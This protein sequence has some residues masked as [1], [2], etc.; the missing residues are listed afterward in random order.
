MSFI[1]G[2][3][4]QKGYEKKRRKLL[5]PF[6]TQHNG[7]NGHQAH[8]LAHASVD[9]HLACKT[10]E[11]IPSDIQNNSS[12]DIDS[13]HNEPPSGNGSVSVSNISTSSE[14]NERG[15]SYIPVSTEEPIFETFSSF[16]TP[17]ESQ[18]ISSQSTSQKSVENLDIHTNCSGSEIIKVNETNIA[19]PT[20]P[21]HKNSPNE[22]ESIVPTETINQLASNDAP[23]S[24]TENSAGHP[25]S[26][27]ENG[28]VPKAKAGKPRS[29][30]RHK[31]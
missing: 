17:L 21:P 24:A 29:R 13:F 18:E 8:Q 15:P 2:D 16:S 26:S 10:S 7:S 14:N 31:R 23:I 30:N 25:A 19:T 1:L 3:I 5:L 12:T 27:I 9:T 6:M 22:S 11:V 28:A 20:I 4:T